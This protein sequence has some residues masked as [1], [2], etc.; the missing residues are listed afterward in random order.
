MQFG[1]MHDGLSH[2]LFAGP[3][4]YRSIASYIAD[5]R[6]LCLPHL[7]LTPPSKGAC[8]NIAMTFGT[9]KLEWFGNPIVKNLKTC[10]FVFDRFHERD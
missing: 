8:R 7:H 4:R 2:L 10:L 9:E 3:A 1:N 6:D 5:D